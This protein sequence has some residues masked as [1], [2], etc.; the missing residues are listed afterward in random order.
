MGS[1]SLKVLFVVP[2]EFHNQ[3]VILH[4]TATVHQ[5]LLQLNGLLQCY[6]EDKYKAK[7]AV[8]MLIHVGLVHPATIHADL[9]ANN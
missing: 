1:L 6:M 4:C 7:W 8:A 2:A 3:C 5:G 9:P